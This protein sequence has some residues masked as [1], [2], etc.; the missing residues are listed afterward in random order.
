MQD[1][2]RYMKKLKQEEK[3]K[4]KIF[5]IVFEIVK[6]ILIHLLVKNHREILN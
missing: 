5:E 4:P 1:Y 6:Q 2:L 3:K